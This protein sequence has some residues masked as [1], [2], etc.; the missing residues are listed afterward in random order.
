MEQHHI[1]RLRPLQALQHGGEGE[2]VRRCVIVRVSVQ[3]EARASQQGH[4]IAPGRIA[5]VDRGARRRRA[6]QLGTDTQCAATAG[7]LDGTRS[8]LA[9]RSMMRSQDQL[10][11][12]TVEL[13]PTRCA[14][15]GLGGLLGQHGSFSAAH[16]VED[17]RV[18]KRVAKHPHPEVD[19]AGERIGAKLGHQA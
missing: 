7:R 2:L 9:T 6:Y 14:D 5:D 19:F 11:D 12:G 3:F 8:A 4:V 1:A 10:F 16:A 18:A 15:I 13:L 17:G